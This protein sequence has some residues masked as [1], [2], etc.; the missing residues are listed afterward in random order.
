MRAVV[1]DDSAVM[2]EGLA[3]LLEDAGIEVVGRA[4]NA[5]EL[6]LKVRSYDPDVAIVDIRMPP[7][8]TDEGI[9]AAREIRASHPGT[10]VLVL[11]P[12]SSTA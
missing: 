4:A 6:L 7:S 11:S 3:R 10:G 8:Q 2:R 12:S 1:A 9:R 5:D